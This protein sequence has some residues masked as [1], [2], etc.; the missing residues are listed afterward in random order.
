MRGSAKGLAPC[1]A[2][3]TRAR[4]SSYLVREIQT[5]RNGTALHFDVKTWRTISFKNATELEE[6]LVGELPPSSAATRGIRDERKRGVLEFS[7]SAVNF[8]R[9]RF[10]A[11]RKTPY[12]S[13]PRS[14][15]SRASGERCT[16]EGNA[17]DEYLRSCPLCRG[18]IRP[19]RRDQPGLHF[20]V[21]CRACGKFLLHLSA[22]HDVTQSPLSEIALADLRHRISRAGASKLPVLSAWMVERARKSPELPTPAEQGDRLIQL[23]GARTTPGRPATVGGTDLGLIGAIDWDGAQFIEAGLIRRELLRRPPNQVEGEEFILTFDGWRRFE[24]LR[25]GATE[26]RRVFMAMRF[27]DEELDRVFATCFKAAALRA[28]FDLFTLAEQPK[29]GIIDNNMRVEIRRSRFLIADL[30]HHNNGAYWEA[31]FAEGLGKP[32]LF[33]CRRDQHAAAHFDA[34]QQQTVLWESTDLASAENQLIAAIRAT[35]PDEAR[36]SDDPA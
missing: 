34:R 36:M 6:K 10:P 29:A 7:S 14:R 2:S 21:H 9:S 27:G 3:G 13:Y 20:E 11:Q 24:E 22:E 32:V 15:C 25:K 28:G 30:T 19:L 5:A 1:D 12:S 33:T 4:D 18:E 16:C 26:S 17:L 35:L 8:T 23:I 31:G